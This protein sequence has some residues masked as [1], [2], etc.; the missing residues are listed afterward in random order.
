M[1]AISS[2]QIR[3]RLLIEHDKQ[4]KG[5]LIYCE[6]AGCGH[7]EYLSNMGASHV[8][9]KCCHGLYDP[10]YLTVLQKEH[11]EDAKKTSER[12]GIE[13]TYTMPEPV[14]EAEVKPMEVD[15][16]LEEVPADIKIRTDALAKKIDTYQKSHDLFVSI[17]TVQSAEMLKQKRLAEEALESLQQD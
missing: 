3:G 2:Q 16:A 4:R 14:A 13:V 5:K 1:G 7:F 15:A 6:N 11:W 8:A 12:N 17:D 10:T 9:C